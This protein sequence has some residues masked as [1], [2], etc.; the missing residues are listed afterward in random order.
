MTAYRGMR[1]SGKYRLWSTIG[2]LAVPSNVSPNSESVAMSIVVGANPAPVRTTVS[3]NCGWRVK[4]QFPGSL[5]N[6]LFAPI[7]LICTLSYVYAEG[8]ELEGDE[9]VGD[10]EQGGRSK[11]DA[12]GQVFTPAA[13][14][15]R[16]EGECQEGQ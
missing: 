16:E 10:G 1:L 7:H 4:S 5:Q 2:V 6:E 3:P 15:S 13:G 9:D 8:V 12:G 14:G 11:T